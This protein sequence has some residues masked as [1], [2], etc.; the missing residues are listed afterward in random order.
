MIRTVIQFLPSLQDGGAET[1]VKDYA[2]LINKELYNLK[3]VTIYDACSTANTKII[4]QNNIEIIPVY[5]NWSLITRIF[6]KIFG[7]LYIPYRLKKII[8]TYNPEVIHIHMNVLK[9][10]KSISKSLTG[11]KLLYTCH[12]VPDRYFAGNNHKEY[13]AADYL[14]KHK[15]LQLIAL[16]NEMKMQLNAMF[17]INNSIVVRNGINLERFRD[18]SETKEKIRKSIGIAE[19]AFVVGHIGRFFEPKNHDFLIEVFNLVQE[20]RK[21]AFLLLIGAGPLKSKI[22]EKIN[23]LNLNNKVMILS[24]R[25]DIPRLLKAMDVFVFPSKYEGFPISL[26]EAQA[27]GL[28]CIV[29]D[30]INTESFLCDD[31]IPLSIDESPSTWCNVILDETIKGKSYGHLNDYDMNRI[32]KRLENI[33]CGEADD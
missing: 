28:R 26:V 3:I 10:I 17:G 23:S 24:H 19:C 13:E 7:K 31:V 14:I 16:H 8:G 9:Y 21:S 27:A 11:I 4:K 12:S 25:T 6:N 18:N 20:H 1:L 22:K 5:K 32:I 2:L 15:G 33:Y 30:K 29:S